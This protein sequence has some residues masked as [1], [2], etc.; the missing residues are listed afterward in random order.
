MMLAGGMRDK[1]G[2]GPAVPCTVQRDRQSG[3][4]VLRVGVGKRATQSRAG[5]ETNI[6]GRIIF[7]SAAFFSVILPLFF[8]F[9][10][11]FWH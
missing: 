11:F 6:D 9:C 1:E 7:L 5:F 10:V 2:S 4:W 3:E 8:R